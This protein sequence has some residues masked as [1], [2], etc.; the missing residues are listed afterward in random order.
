MAMQPVASH[1]HESRSEIDLKKAGLHRYWEDD[2]SISLC[3]AWRIGGGAPVA[4][5][6]GEPAPPEM[7]AHIKAGGMVIAHNSAFDRH[8]WNKE[9]PDCP[10][11]I[12]QCDCTMARAAAMAL[13]QGL[14][15]L[16][17]ALKSPIQK[18]RE[19]SRLMMRLCKPIGRDE[20]GGPLFDEDLGKHERNVE[21]CINDVLTEQSIDKIVPLLSKRERHIW[22][23]DQ[24]INDRGVAVDVKLVERAF[25][26]VQVAALRAHKRM[27]DL[28]QGHVH[29]TS[30]VAKLIA[31]LN[32]RGI[33]CESVAKGEADE[34]LLRAGL[35]NDPVAAEAISLRRE[36]AKASTAKYQ[37][38]LNSVCKDG[39]VRGSLRYHGASTGRWAGSGMQP[40]NFPRV[41]DQQSVIETL[42]ILRDA[43]S[44]DEAC[45]AIRLFIGE[46]MMALSQCLRA[47]LIAKPGHRLMGG[48]YAN[49]EGRVNAWL[50]GEHWKVSAFADF[51]NGVGDDLYSLAYSRAFHVPV[52]LVT[53][54]Q[55]Q[56]GKVMELSMGFQGGWRAFE[57][58]GANYGIS[59][60]EERGEQ[61]KKA[62]RDAHPAITQSWWELQ[63]AAIEAVERPGL[64]IPALDG[65]VQYKSA[66]GML[67]C[68]LPSLRC[69]VYAAPRIK[70]SE[71]TEERSSRRQVIFDGVDS[72]T[73]QW[74]PKALYGG[75]QCE[76]IVQAV[77][78]DILA[79]GMLRLEE[80]GYPLVLTVHD[81]NIAEVENGVGDTGQFAAL[82]E[83]LPSW[84]AGLPVAV[85]AWEDERY[86]K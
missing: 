22:I 14:D 49:I 24:K 18:D 10:L 2:S 15:Q 83:H 63:D 75:L 5:R 62:W 6:R 78:R 30:E 54:D 86:V 72:V 73:K 36:A 27:R 47:M 67:W 16:G 84:A 53:G 70:W 58:M 50:A 44:G 76:N 1:D 79:E 41:R 51:D 55:R 80:A 29:K 20:S 32:R 59:V 13:P 35:M 52:D 42:Q 77:A 26:A 28:T 82:M 43:P 11:P 74:G 31:W 65:R 9:F 66:H 19:G 57:K 71:A 81:E 85:K 7:V 48:D 17:Q 34:L 45:D 3:M 37:A 33:P 12:E 68:Q 21:Y 64:S 8:A 56:I 40:Q 25:A 46:P 39:R 60:G 69:L 23:L 61:L 4:W 38:I